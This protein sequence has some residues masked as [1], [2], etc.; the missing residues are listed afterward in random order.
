MNFELN[1]EQLALRDSLARL[2]GDVYGFEKR[3]A[4]AASATGWSLP[5]WQQLAALGLTAL[6]LP[7]AHGGFG[8]GAADLMPVMQEL[9]KALVLEPFLSSIV[10]GA[11][12]VR[13]AADEVLQVQLLPDVASGELRL[14]WAHDEEAARHA[15][16][17]I[18]TRARQQDGQWLL[19]GAKCNVLHAPS[20]HR[21]VVSARTAGEPGDAHGVAL[22]HV[23]ARAAGIACRAHRLVDDTPAGELRF[24]AARAQPLGDPHDGAAAL[25]A[26]EG[27][28]AMGTAAVCADAV[29]A[30]E[31]A[32]ALAIDY[33]GTRRQFGRAIGENQ[34]LRHR[35]AEMLVALEMSRSMAMV[36]AVAADDLDAPGA[37][38][39]LARAKLVIGRHARAVCHAAV[40]L[41]GGIGM[42]EE[43]AVGHCL[44]RVTLIDQLF[45][46]VEAQAM[47]LAAMA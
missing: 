22:F 18:E 37:R 20:A 46:D 31:T 2:L 7:Q 4:I 39:D 3:R 14:A 16:L 32:Y 41:H 9:G 1:D 36:A 25:R 6:P 10:L 29:G 8:G 30:M 24:N 44:R 47:R 28:L 33:L 45:G 26:L 11:T 43:Y 38:A 27:T 21:F 19:D 35:A 34:A 13:L 42:T 15:P 40:Q 23:D 17:W 12:A 5:A